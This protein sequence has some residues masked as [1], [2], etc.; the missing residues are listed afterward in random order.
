MEKVATG[1]IEMTWDPEARLAVI[2]FE[3]ATQATGRDAVVLVGALTD[4]IGTEGKPFGLLGD[5][6]RL[7]GLDAEYR[8]VWGGFLRRHREDSSVAF[9]NMNAVVRIAAEMF[10]IGT[11]LRLKAFANEAEARAWLRDNGIAA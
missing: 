8:S 11:G 4:W 9:F 5:G 2:R 3:R 6:G 10:R 1:A 7:S